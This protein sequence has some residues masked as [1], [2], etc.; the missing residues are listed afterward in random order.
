MG[1]QFFVTAKLLGLAAYG[2]GVGHDTEPTKVLFP[3]DVA[4]QEGFQRLEC[5]L[6]SRDPGHAFDQR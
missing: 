6:S 5:Q 1:Q 2:L 4:L 3:L